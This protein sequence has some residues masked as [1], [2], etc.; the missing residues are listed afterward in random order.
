MS[1]RK[2]LVVAFLVFAF[3]LLTVTLI[4]FGVVSV[5]SHLRSFVDSQAVETERVASA[6][7]RA[8]DSRIA[9]S[10]SG[11]SERR[12]STSTDAPSRSEVA[13][14]ATCTIAP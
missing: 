8:T 9:S 4:P 5:H 2:N 14:N 1:L 10:S 3:G 11:T 13:S 12:S 6:L 7:A